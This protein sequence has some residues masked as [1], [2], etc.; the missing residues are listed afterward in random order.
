MGNSI[1]NVAS[2]RRRAVL[3]SGTDTRRVLLKKAHGNSFYQQLSADIYLAPG[4]LSRNSSPGLPL[5]YSVVTCS[6]EPHVFDSSD[7][8][9]RFHS[10]ILRLSPDSVFA[11]EK[12]Y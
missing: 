8:D 10:C 11:P 7:A 1:V 2:P 9:N 5:N 4:G 3:Q 12:L 6:P